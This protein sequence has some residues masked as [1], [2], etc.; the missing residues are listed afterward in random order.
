MFQATRQR[1]AL[2]YTAVTAV[3]LL[4]FASGVYLY[5]RTTLIERVDDTLNHVVEIIERSLVIEQTEENERVLIS[6]DTT[7]PTL[8]VNVEAS[9]RDNARAVEDDHIDL[10]WFNPNG[11][12]VWSTLSQRLPV[13]LHV[14]PA[15]ETVR[16]SQEELFRQITERI[17]VN[18]Q[19]LGYLRVSHPWFEVTKPSRQLIIDLGLGISFMIGAVAAIGWLLSGIAITPVKESY[20]QLKQFTADASHELRNPIAVIQT[21]A[22]VAL[23]DPNPDVALQQ[24]QFQV[25]ER[26]TRRLGRLVDDLLFLARQESGLI[27]LAMEPIDLNLLL[28]E[29]T[30]EQQVIAAERHIR[31]IFSTD[32]ESSNSKDKI[33]RSSSM[34][35]LEAANEDLI[36]T[37]DMGQLTRLFTNLISNAVQYTSNQGEVVVM[38][39]SIKQQGQQWVQI[40]I[41]DTGIGMDSE[42]LSHIF[43]RFYRADPAR[44]KDRQIETGTGLGLAI[45]KVIV[46]NHRGHISIESQLNRGT[47]VTVLLPRFQVIATKLGGPPL[48]VQKG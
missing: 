16:V 18:D 31:L 14:N 11:E 13:P 47:I 4:L 35:P 26:L 29:V 41:Q 42:T 1:L 20:Q 7:G 40:R 36:V 12:L 24:K 3:L 10:E 32:T 46:D 28:T 9:F 30:E 2:W 6:L 33:S 5:V 48:A 27:P 45:A 17:Q 22:Q 21:N 25:I 19:I 38:A 15:G 39:K 44:L 37:G 23:L 8:R 43:D 34:G